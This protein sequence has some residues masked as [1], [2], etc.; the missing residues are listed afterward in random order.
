MPSNRETERE[1][2]YP[3]L[4]RP[5]LDLI[6]DTLIWSIR[7]RDLGHRLDLAETVV[8]DLTGFYTRRWG[9]PPSIVGRVERVRELAQSAAAAA[10]AAV[11]P[12]EQ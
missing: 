5:A 12:G 6:I 11:T 1:L 7:Q 8:S 2:G 4:T 9:L 3:K 10:D